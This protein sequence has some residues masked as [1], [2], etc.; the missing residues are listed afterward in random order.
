MT[1]DV[2]CTVEQ[3]SQTFQQ[4]QIAYVLTMLSFTDAW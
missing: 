3:R 2:Q 4:S 1:A